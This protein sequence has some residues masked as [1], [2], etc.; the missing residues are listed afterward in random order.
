MKACLRDCSFWRSLPLPGWVRVPAGTRPLAELSVI[1]D[2]LPT[3]KSEASDPICCKVSLG[4]AADGGPETE[5]LPCAAVGAANASC[6]C[7]NA[8]KR[9][10]SSADSS[11]EPP[12]DEWLLSPPPLA[13]SRPSSPSSRYT[14]RGG[15]KTSE[16][17]VCVS[18]SSCGTS[19]EARAENTGAG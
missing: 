12:V 2:P 1:P 14:S 8:A 17:G 11:E 9:S 13:S 4:G 16:F 5:L 15:C 18:P 7:R 19:A 3:P 6:S 10:F